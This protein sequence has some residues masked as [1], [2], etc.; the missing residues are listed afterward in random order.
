MPITAFYAA[1]L[2]FLY[3]VLSSRVI[4]WRRAQKVAIGDGADR[5]LLRRI[6]V[7]GNFAEYAPLFL[8]LFGLAEQLAAP[9]PF[10]HTIGA[11]FLAGRL[12][13]AYGLS[14]T[15]QV[16]PMRVAGMVLSLLGIGAAAI[17]CLTL[18]AGRGIV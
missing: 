15:P 1:L 7:H 12:L 16:L 18:A 14:Q 4:V 6:R 11:A 13:H 9:R 10:L 2:A 5:E 3:L 8:I 17:L